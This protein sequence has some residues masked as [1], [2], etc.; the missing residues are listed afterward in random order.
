MNDELRH[1]VHAAVSAIR[2]RT[3]FKAG[4]VITGLGGLVKELRK[5]ASVPYEEIP[6]FPEFTRLV[7]HILGRL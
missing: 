1:R 2:R 3:A 6:G 7:K 4:T 5:E